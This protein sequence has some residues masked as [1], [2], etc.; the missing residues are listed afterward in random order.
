MYFR[1]RPITQALMEPLVVIE[2]KVIGQAG[3]EGWHGRIFLQVNVLVL[4][5]APQA[6]DKNVIQSP[7]SPIHTDPNVGSIQ[8]TGKG[9]RRELSTL[10]GVENLRLT[11][12]QGLLQDLKTEM[13]IQGI[14]E[15]PGQDI[16]AK[17]VYNR[18]QVHKTMS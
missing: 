4:D 5:A 1:G 6:L 9:Q 8:E 10:I 14:R 2:D 3:D 17:P 13:T 16:A 11:S 18:D 12:L 15:L 7:A